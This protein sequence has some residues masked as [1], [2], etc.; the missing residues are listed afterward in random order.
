MTLEEDCLRGWN[1]SGT[2]FF[3]RTTGQD[4]GAVY[5]AA[6]TAGLWRFDERLL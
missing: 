2:I 1:G 4:L 5:E 3:C 6:R